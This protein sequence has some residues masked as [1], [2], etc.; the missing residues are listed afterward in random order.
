[1]WKMKRWLHAGLCVVQMELVQHHVVQYLPQ[2]ICQL[3]RH[4]N[5]Q[6]L[7]Y[8]LLVDEIV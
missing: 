3:G 8:I 1:M 7:R 4:R 2:N 5:K 6:L